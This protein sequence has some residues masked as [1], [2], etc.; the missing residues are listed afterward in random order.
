MVKRTEL[1]PAEMKEKEHKPRHNKA[2]ILKDKLNKQ[3]S[4]IKLLKIENEELKEEYL[5]KTAE[6]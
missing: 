1:K 4:E 2:N 6:M 5:R 3:E